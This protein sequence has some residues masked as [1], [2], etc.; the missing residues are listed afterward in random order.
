QPFEIG[1]Y[2]VQS[3]WDGNGV[4]WATQPKIADEPAAKASLNP[5][6]P[7]VRV[8]VTALVKRG[9]EVKRGEKNAV[10]KYG[11]LLKVTK[12]LPSGFSGPQTPRP[13]PVNPPSFCVWWLWLPV[14]A[15]VLFGLSQSKLGVVQR[16]AFRFSFAY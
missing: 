2:E 14:I 4:T 11:W 6:V 9:G 10:P 8:D 7:E 13:A 15:L 16:I 12:P 5:N 1:V 3:E